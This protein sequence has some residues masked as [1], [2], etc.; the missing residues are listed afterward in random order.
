MDPESIQASHF[1]YLSPEV[2]S[3]EAYLSCDDSYA[4]GLLALELIFRKR[5]YKV[6]R[7]WS[8]DQFAREVKPLQMLE[9]YKVLEEQ[10]EDI[11]VLVSKCFGK[12]D[13]R[14]RVGEFLDV[15]FPQFDIMQKLT[16]E[17]KPDSHQRSFLEQDVLYRR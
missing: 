5:P 10:P 8:L 3:G 9:V 13:D 1:V 16:E 17:H 2:L 11:T 4:T 14:P 6:Q 7:E 15:K 12:A